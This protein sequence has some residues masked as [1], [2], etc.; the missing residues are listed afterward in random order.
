MKM[1]IFLKVDGMGFIGRTKFIYK[2][3]VIVI[4]SQLAKLKTLTR[5]TLKL[6]PL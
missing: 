4:V 3:K 6:R 2:E 1:K 5:F